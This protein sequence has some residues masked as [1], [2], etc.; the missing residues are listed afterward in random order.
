M[1]REKS[2][3]VT[4]LKIEEIPELTLAE[5]CEAYHISPQLIAEIVDF[6]VVEPLSDT[7]DLHFNQNDLRRIRTIIRLQH[8]LELNIAGAALVVDLIE[9][10]ETMRARVEVL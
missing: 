10:L 4:T 7:D 5:L 3:M 8:D 1:P 2:V 6:G 9:E